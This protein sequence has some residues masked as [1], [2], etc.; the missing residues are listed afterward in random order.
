[1]TFELRR[2][3]PDDA[4]RWNDFVAQ[5]RTGTFLH[6]RRFME[7]HA[8][9]FEDHSLLIEEGGEL[10]AVLPA[11]LK[12]GVL[13]SHGGLTYGGLLTGPGLTAAQMVGIVGALI[14]WLRDAGVTALH[15]KAVPHVFHR[16]PAEE[17]IYALHQAGARLVRCDL[18]AVIDLQAGLGLAKSKR[19]GARRAEK[20][21]LVVSEVT[22]FGPFWQILEARLA[23]AHDASP[24]HSP[25]EIATLHAA[26]PDNIRLFVAGHTPDRPEAGVVIFDCGTAV[27]A[28]Y[29]A[30]TESGRRDGG[31]DAIL[32]H[33]I[34]AVFS[35]RR[36]F[37]FGISTTDGGRELNVGLARQ[38]EMFGARGT[39]FAQY[40]LDLA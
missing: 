12:A 6:D 30:S 40:R 22:D 9:R 14:R 13:T 31:L 8:D 18:G 23:D 5:S 34:R 38:K 16:L 27:H 21:G 35:D 4:A 36:H 29:M 28:Q 24:V 19:Q 33:L 7:Y 39:V 20:A 1:M 32:A 3:A 2:Y 15:Y 10:V 25:V 26:F 17:D 11:N 37:S